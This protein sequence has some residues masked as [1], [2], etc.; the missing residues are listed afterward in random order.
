MN[1]ITV[2]D[3]LY[4]LAVDGIEAEVSAPKSNDGT[5]DLYVLRLLSESDIR[6]VC[7]FRSS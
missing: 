3:R 4:L 1:V 5:I 7:R 2:S 6:A